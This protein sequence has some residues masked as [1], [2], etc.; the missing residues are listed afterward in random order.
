V[1]LRVRAVLFLG[2]DASSEAAGTSSTCN[3]ISLVVSAVCRDGM[4]DVELR[5][6]TEMLKR[7]QKGVKASSTTTLNGGNK[8]ARAGGRVRRPDRVLSV[9]WYLTS[10]VENR[11]PT[12]NDGRVTTWDSDPKAQH[13]EGTDGR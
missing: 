6:A 5:R 2:P 12:V 11:R 1:A 9:R 10:L 4:R 7:A 13:A 8:N 3:L